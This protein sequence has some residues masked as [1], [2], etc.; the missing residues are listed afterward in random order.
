MKAGRLGI[1][2]VG[3]IF[4][5]SACTD[6]FGGSG[7]AITSF[8]ASP[9]TVTAGTASVLAWSVDSSA[10]SISINNGVGTVTTDTDDRATV[11]PATTTTYTLTATSGSGTST[12]N[13]TV[14]VATGNG[15]SGGTDPQPPVEPPV[16]GAPT[17]TFG[18]STSATG[19]F[20]SDADGVISSDDDERII[21][22]AAGSTFYAE[23]E[24]TDPDG[25]ADIGVLLVNSEPAGLSGELPTGPFTIGEPTGNCTL[26][27]GA[28][29]VTCVYPITVAPGTQDIAS[30]PDAGDEFAY[31]FRVAVTDGAGNPG[32]ISNRGYVNIQ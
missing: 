2:S 17:G 12:R 30:L 6:L 18:V 11:T 28:T 16:T 26:G 10:T 29:S 13:V 21:S 19:T 5:L 32:G 14:T 1:L 8:T 20:T 7:P 31:V 24:Y 4:G 3:L 27:S 25:I 22:V 9:P 23:V 15:G